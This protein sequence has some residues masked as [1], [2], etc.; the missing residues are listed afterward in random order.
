M[1]KM[2]SFRFQQCLSQFSMLLVELSSRTGL[3]THLSK[4]VFWSPKIKI[5]EHGGSSFFILKMFRIESKFRKCKKKNREN[6]FGF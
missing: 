1:V 2:L 5:H 6:I 4:H 3:L